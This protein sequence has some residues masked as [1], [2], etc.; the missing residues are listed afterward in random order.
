MSLM[1]DRYLGR[2]EDHQIEI[3]RT[4][5]DKQVEIRVDGVAI[6]TESVALPHSWEQQKQFSSATCGKS[7]TLTAHGM[8]KKLFGVLPY[9]STYAIEVDGTPVALSK[10]G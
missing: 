7:H 3:V 4:N 9:D 2:F 1:G 10:A 6:A 8:L 5:L